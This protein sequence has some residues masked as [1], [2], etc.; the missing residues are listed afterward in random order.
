LA[1]V[2]SKISTDKIKQAVVGKKVSAVREIVT[3]VSGLDKV[4]VSVWPSWWLGRIP[5][6]SRNINV[7]TQ[8]LSQENIKQ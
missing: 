8:Y 1:K 6:L 4:D 2:S 7:K 3:N 5:D